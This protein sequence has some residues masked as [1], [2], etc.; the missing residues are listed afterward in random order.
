MAA[1]ALGVLL[2][3]LVRR[4]SARKHGTATEPARRL[5]AV[6]ANTFNGS[7][8]N[9]VELEPVRAATTPSP[10]G[11]L[12]KRSKSYTESPSVAA[13]RN[14][15]EAASKQ[16]AVKDQF[17]HRAAG[18]SDSDDEKECS[19]LPRD[20]LSPV[21]SDQ[22]T[23]IV[24]F[25]VDGNLAT[26][27]L[28]PTLFHLWQRKLLPRDTIIMGYARPKGGGGRFSDA[29]E[30][31]AHVRSL[32]LGQQA[33]PSVTD[34]D[35]F[36]HCCFFQPGQ[37]GDVECTRALLDR[38]DVEEH[39]REA[40]R[41]LGHKWLERARTRRSGVH[42]PD[43]PRLIAPGPGMPSKAMGAPL[44]NRVRMYY[45]SVPPFLYA[46]ICQ[47]I[48]EAREL[49][50]QPPLS[51]VNSS[52]D[53]DLVYASG[54]ASAGAPTRA[55]PVV[56]QASEAADATEDS[57]RQASRRAIHSARRA[58][59][60]EERFVLEKPFGR[61]HRTCCELMRSIRRAG[62]TA[63]DTFYIDH[64]LG[65]ELVMNLLVLRFAN[66]CFGAIWN[67]QHIKSV[68]VIFKEKVGCE[69]RA[70]YF[71]EYGIMRD[72]MQNHL[73]QMVALVA[74]EQPLSFSAEHIRHEKLKVLHA[75]RPL[76][77]DD[78]V[79]GQ[80]AG[81]LDDEGIQDKESCTETF[82]AAVLHVH[83][84]RWDGVPFVLK[85]GKALNDSKVE[86]RVQ[87]HSVPGVVGA[88]P[89]RRAA[90]R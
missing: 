45:L 21:P 1:A 73:M 46:Q 47:G 36:S 54:A 65:K 32:L 39:S 50:A 2:T 74:M 76:T 70:G 53:R 84:P 69:G 62:L 86:L 57:T 71:D 33:H 19:L 66:V 24:V 75:C 89:A 83:N 29:A 22:A 6:S 18:E 4:L 85:A 13:A 48:V 81:Y 64:Y 5:P 27:K 78:V 44:P 3:E 16:K 12:R 77:A 55:S 28:L 88:T 60:V 37:F 67:R 51:R 72:V 49:D 59:R 20:L 79:T 30:F 10:T 23:T 43:A 56:A 17:S 25:G 34:V 63:A 7:S 90:A 35:D 61:D 11:K 52:R 31:R 42:D 58:G 26:L 38:L 82:A 14:E 68:Q 87:F 9:L 40:A 41:S 15:R 80:Y 8:S